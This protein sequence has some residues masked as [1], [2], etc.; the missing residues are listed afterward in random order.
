MGKASSKRQSRKTETPKETGKAAADS[1]IDSASSRKTGS[2]SGHRWTFLTNHATAV[3]ASMNWK[4]TI[5]DGETMPAFLHIMF[6]NGFKNPLGA[7]TML[8]SFYAPVAAYAASFGLLGWSTAPVW[9]G[10]ACVMF[11]GRLFAL[12]AELYL[13]RRYMLEILHTDVQA[14]REKEK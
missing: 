1:A 8:G 12:A 13:I 4:S 14:R 9:T 5:Q 10:L 6:A 11:I 2:E 3:K 7:V